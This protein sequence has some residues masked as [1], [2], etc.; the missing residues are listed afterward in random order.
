M[1][2]LNISKANIF[3]G[4]CLPKLMFL[5]KYIY[6]FI[7]SKNHSLALI[8]INGN[9]GELLGLADEIEDRVFKMS[10]IKL[11]KEPEIV[12]G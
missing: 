3:E 10:G 4:S 7:I 6:P 11:Y 1:K 8:N 9:T 5:K 2:L 12:Q